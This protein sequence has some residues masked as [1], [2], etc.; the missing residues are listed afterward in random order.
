M[1]A[2]TGIISTVAGNG[3]FTFDV[4]HGDGGP[5]TG[6]TI[7][8]ESVAVDGA[9]NLYIADPSTLRV[10]KV[11]AATG[12]ISTVAGNGQAGYSGGAGPATSGNAIL[13]RGRAAVDRMGRE[14]VHRGD[15]G[16]HSIRKVTASTGIISTVAGNGQHG[17]M[18]DG[19]PAT[20]AE[21]VFPTS[22][23]VDGAG[24]LYIGDANIARV[25]KVTAATGIISTLAGNGGSGSAGDLCTWRPTATVEFQ[26]RGLAVDEAEDLYIA[27]PD[28]QRI[29]KVTTSVAPLHFTSTPLNTTSIDSLQ[30]VTVNN[31][32]NSVLTFTNSASGGNLER[33]AGLHHREQ[34]NL[35]PIHRRNSRRSGILVAAGI[36]LLHPGQSFGANGHGGDHRFYCWRSQT[37]I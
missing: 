21:L 22:V 34:F 1:T 5:A 37:I 33:P 6:A 28:N 19:G 13:P 32:G 27:D 12:I 3:Q 14:P 25:R 9:G 4:E 18:G 8:P 30:M 2:A 10:R 36:R 20:S 23:A 11:T 29:R 24:N 35:I 7:Y 26:A 17:F 15:T 16:N 31:I